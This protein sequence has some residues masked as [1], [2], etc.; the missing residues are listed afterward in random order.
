MGCLVYELCTGKHPFEANTQ[1]AL[2]L[3]IVVGKYAPI[4][5]QYSQTLVWLVR[6]CLSVDYKRRPSIEYLL[7][8]QSVMDLGA[9]Y[10]IYLEKRKDNINEKPQ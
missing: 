9:K 6:L 1:A 7:S 8:Q 4:P 2:A 5:S 10:G 3:K